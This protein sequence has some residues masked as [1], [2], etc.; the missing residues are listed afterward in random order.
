[1]RLDCPGTEIQTGAAGE[2]LCVDGLGAPVAW[3]AVEEF[4]VSQLE[5]DQLAGAFAAG[6]VICATGWAIGRGFRYVL[7]MLR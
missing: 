2:A 1:M 6:F 7:S 5:A 3:Q 4:D